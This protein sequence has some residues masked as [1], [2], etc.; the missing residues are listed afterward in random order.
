[1][2]GQP[3]R[4]APLRPTVRPCQLRVRVTRSD[5]KR[6]S[7][8]AEHDD[9]NYGKGSERSDGLGKS[10]RHRARACGPYF[11]RGHQPRRANHAGRTEIRRA[12]GGTRR[13][14]GH[15]SDPGRATRDLQFTAFNQRTTPEIDREVT[16]V[17]ADQVGRKDGNELLQGSYR[18]V[19]GR[20]RPGAQ[21]RA[22]M[23]CEAFH[24]D[25]GAYR[26]FL[27]DEALKDQT[28]GRSRRTDDGARSRAERRDAIRNAPRGPSATFR[29]PSVEPDSAAHSNE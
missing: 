2:R 29:T 26:P 21:D 23:P 17:G 6:R 9:Q 16:L 19:S 20:A 22:W 11:G 13:S 7:G 14:Q 8:T 15:R 12:R 5:R 27:P 4:G 28:V 25:G 1:M 10:G 24:Q 18:A 3:C